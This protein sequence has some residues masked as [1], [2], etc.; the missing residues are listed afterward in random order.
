MKNVNKPIRIPQ[1]LRDTVTALHIDPAE[2]MQRYIDGFR[3]YPYFS[4]RNEQEKLSVL[5]RI[6]HGMTEFQRS[7]HIYID[8]I[9]NEINQ[10]YSKLLIML[11]NEQQLSPREHDKQSVAL[12]KKWEREVRLLINYPEELTLEGGGV[13]RLSFDFM[14]TNIDFGH[15]ISRYVQ[16]YMKRISMA[17]LYADAYP[18]NQY[19]NKMVMQFFEDLW[20]DKGNVFLARSKAQTIVIEKYDKKFGD[21][22]SDMVPVK[23]YKKRLEKFR[24]LIKEWA[25]KMAEIK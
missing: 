6:R 3:F 10:R 8:P 16:M 15:K 25:A 9:L 2:M 1:D 13:L 18:G 17:Y 12:I 11:S 7:G 24:P 20:N 21:L 23:N 14:L 22:F 4:T 5:S 19:N